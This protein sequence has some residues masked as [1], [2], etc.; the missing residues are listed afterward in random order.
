MQG[1]S[2]YE[3]ALKSSRADFGDALKPFFA[4]NDRKTLMLFWINFSSNGVGMTEP[5]EGWIH[6]AGENCLKL[7]F[8]KLGKY[9][10]E[11]A[12]HEANHHHMMI[13]DTKKLVD[14][15]NEIYNPKM[16]ANEL[17]RR[18]Y[19]ES[20]MRYRLLF[21]NYV[22]SETPYCQAAM[23]YEIEN[24]SC[25]YGVESLNHVAKVLGKDFLEQL[26]FLSEHVKVDTW[27]TELNKKAITGLIE[28]HPETLRH[29]IESGQQVLKTYSGFLTDCYYLS[30]SK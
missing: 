3:A 1:Y 24:L 7:G 22:N 5:V 6:R 19:R 11:H 27:H 18:P 14:T 23:E 2:E 9:L 10:C 16:D 4:E 8:E 20:V 29:L 21:D 26:S 12:A 28:S 17:L 30:V 13:K 15:W 25:T